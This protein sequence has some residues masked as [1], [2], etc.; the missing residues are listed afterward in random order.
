MYGAADLRCV[1]RISSIIADTTSPA[2]RA[3]GVLDEL[4]HLIPYAAAQ[5]CTWDD[6]RQTH[7]TIAARGY[8]TAVR[9]ALNGTRYRDDL[10]W[11]FL[12]K[13]DGAVFW[14]DCPFNRDESPFYS[15]SLAPQGYR[16][17]GTV[18]LRDSKRGYIGMLVM[19]LETYQAPAEA[20]Q[21]LL[22]I[23]GAGLA[24]LVDRFHLARRIAAACA[25][26]RAAAVYHAQHGW[27]D[28]CGEGLP[29]A[30]FLE[31]LGIPGQ[32][33]LPTRSS[34]RDP[35]VQ[36]SRARIDGMTSIGYEIYP[37]HDKNCEVLLTWGREAAPYHLTARE[38]EVLSALAQGLSNAEIGRQLGVSARTVSTHV[39][40]ILN[41]LDV[42]TRAA[43]AS[44][45]VR[46]GLDR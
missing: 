15:Q 25:P 44:I 4:F 2:E 42:R 39:E 29:P 31:V 43:A 32:T 14:K 24:P 37:I 11:Q 35:G 5:I 38:S 23:V 1:R 18:L 21:A 36:W 30:R 45:A 9:M 27:V 26:H 33:D 46:M 3:E 22:G 13:S 17:G 28:I 41:K 19:N 6:Q 16:E 40:R 20:E 7:Y 12:E 8:P 10:V 34:W